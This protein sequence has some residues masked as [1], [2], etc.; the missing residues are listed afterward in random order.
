MLLD[1]L[2]RGSGAQHVGM[3]M[4]NAN[5]LRLYT[6]GTYSMAFSTLSWDVKMVHT[7]FMDPEMVLYS[8]NGLWSEPQVLTWMADLMIFYLI[9]VLLI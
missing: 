1:I 5:L 7:H 3:L 8:F 6:L 2:P 4:R 9:V